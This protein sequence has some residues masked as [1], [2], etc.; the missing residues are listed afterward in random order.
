MNILFGSN[1]ALTWVI[2]RKKIK[3]YVKNRVD[4]IDKLIFEGYSL[5]CNLPFFSIS[6]RYFIDTTN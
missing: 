3:P 6:D 4:E 5:L 2:T 1:I